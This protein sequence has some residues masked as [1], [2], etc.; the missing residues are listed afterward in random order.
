MKYMGKATNTVRRMKFQLPVNHFKP[1][2][3]LQVKKAT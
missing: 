1:K 3:M 2:L